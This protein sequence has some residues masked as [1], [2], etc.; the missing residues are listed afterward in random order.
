MQKQNCFD[1]KKLK[2]PAE[3]VIH[4]CALMS[5][6][7]DLYDAEL[8]SKIMDSV[9]LVLSCAYKVLMQQA[10]PAPLLLYAPPEATDD[11]EEEN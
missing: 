9:K 11:E 8:Q 3:I 1:N 6:W 7:A 5:F 2:N 10:R 4:A